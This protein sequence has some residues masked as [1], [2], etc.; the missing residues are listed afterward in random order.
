M[1]R[2]LIIACFAGVQIPRLR[3]SGL[4]GW[5]LNA[6]SPPQREREREREESEFQFSTLGTMPPPR[7]R[8][9]LFSP[10]DKIY[11]LRNSEAP[12]NPFIFLGGSPV[13]EKSP[14]SLEVAGVHDPSIRRPPPSFRVRPGFVCQS[15]KCHLTSL[16]PPSSRP[17]VRFPPSRPFFHQCPLAD[18]Q[19]HRPHYLSTPSLLSSLATLR[20]E[21]KNEAAGAKEGGRRHGMAAF[22]HTNKKSSQK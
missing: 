17:A 2:A 14:E 22:T 18:W 4:A 8:P 9:L 19:W 16:D 5:L 3:L 13:R 10:R 12:S 15:S 7:F 6:H 20:H 21:Y 11:F 1:V